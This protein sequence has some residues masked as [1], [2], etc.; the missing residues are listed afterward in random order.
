MGD[1]L[2]SPE[3]STALKSAATAPG[4]PINGKLGHWV[5]DRCSWCTRTETHPRPLAPSAPHPHSLI[6][7]ERLF[8]PMFFLCFLLFLSLFFCL[9]CFFSCSAFFSRLGFLSATVS[10]GSY[11]MNPRPV[12]ENHSRIP[13]E[14]RRRGSVGISGDDS[15]QRYQE[16]SSSV[17]WRQRSEEKKEDRVEADSFFH[18]ACSRRVSKA[19]IYRLKVRS[20]P[21]IETPQ[22]QS[23][24]IPSLNNSFIS[25][26]HRMK[27][28]RGVNVI[29]R[30][31]F[32]T[33]SVDLR[34]RIP[35]IV[36]RESKILFLRVNFKNLQSSKKQNRRFT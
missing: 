15:E 34:C 21:D 7:P 13:R 12:N 36:R 3:E 11:S 19:W 10:T 23:G 20:W 1:G 22:R 2:K 27:S 18:I 35:S 30:L 6:S 4:R 14:P 26:F 24:K 33:D 5:N 29:F 25:P 31:Q 8:F 16:A 9:S 28:I 17:A 32:R